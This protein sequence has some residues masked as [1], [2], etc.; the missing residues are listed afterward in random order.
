M[1]TGDTGPQLAREVRK[2]FARAMGRVLP[3]LSETTAKFLEQMVRGNL[4]GLP[5]SAQEIL[6]AP[7]AFERARQPWEQAA[8]R[9][10]LQAHHDQSAGKETAPASLGE[11]KLVD[12]TVVEDRILAS[13]LGNV[14]TEAVSD[15]WAQLQIRV[16]RLE[17]S[18]QLDRADPLRAEVFVHCLLAAWREC[19]LSQPLWTLVQEGL[20][21]V[22]VEVY[23]KQYAAVNNALSGPVSRPSWI[24]GRACAGP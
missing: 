2:H 1:P 8:R 17:E 22:L 10:W 12:D 18:S 23:G 3:R 9:R 7:R 11:L 21:P 6:E 16:Q 13:R 15:V 4:R 24:S 20:K 5:V 19:G 14:I